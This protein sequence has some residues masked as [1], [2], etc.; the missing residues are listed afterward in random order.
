MKSLI[1]T[2]EFTD[3][4][5]A[6]YWK[7]LELETCSLVTSLAWERKS[8]IGN[9]YSPV[10]WFAMG[11]RQWLP[12]LCWLMLASSFS[13]RGKACWRPLWCDYTSY[14]GR[15]KDFQ[16]RENLLFFGGKQ[17]E[18]M[19]TTLHFLSHTTG[20]KL[21]TQGVANI[22]VNMELENEHWMVK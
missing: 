1:C 15:Q 7:I 14:E 22:S 2:N 16:K 11:Q 20:A 10:F 19:F 6:V 3:H 12:P 18:E 5:S 4:L 21:K 8:I 17:W 9:I 13:C